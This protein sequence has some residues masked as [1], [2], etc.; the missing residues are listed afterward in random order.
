M[1]PDL[2]AGAVA[3]TIHQAHRELVVALTRPECVMVWLNDVAE[4]V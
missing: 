3:P 2:K 4:L 1:V